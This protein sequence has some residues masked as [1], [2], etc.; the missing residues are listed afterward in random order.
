M[1]DNAPSIKVKRNIG[2]YGT[3]YQHYLLVQDGWLLRARGS[4]NESGCST[5]QEIRGRTGYTETLENCKNMCCDTK[6]LQYH[7]S[8]DHCGCFN[9]CDFKRPASDYG[10]KADVYEQHNFGMVS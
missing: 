8:S 9:N 10:S 4:L 1:N 7:V 3:S 5:E 6:L 2:E